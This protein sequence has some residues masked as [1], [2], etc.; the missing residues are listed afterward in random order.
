MDG[1]HDYSVTRWP[2]Y[3]FNICPFATMKK[4]PKAKNN[5]QFGFSKYLINCKKICKRL[6]FANFFPNLVTLRTNSKLDDSNLKRQESGA[7]HLLELSQKAW[8]RCHK[9]I[10]IKYSNFSTLN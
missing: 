6:I 1:T 5:L 10:R 9:Q 7:L 3:L 8:S 4:R 2:N